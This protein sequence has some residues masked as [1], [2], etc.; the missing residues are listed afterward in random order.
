MADS[1]SHQRSAQASMD[2]AAQR[3]ATLVLGVAILLTTAAEIF[4]L[5]VWGMWLFPDGSWPGKLVWTLTCGL[6][7][8]AVM[9]TLTLIWAEPRR[10]RAAAFWLAAASVA[11]VGSYCA[12]LCSRI[13]ARF[14]YFGGSEH[15]VL[16]VASGVL[17]ALVGGL[18]YGWLLYGRPGLK[19]D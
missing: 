12:W 13:D 9:G 14:D 3:R 7:M 8:G 10:G 5:L 17:P 19:P 11:L 15:G 4:Y 18:L 6:A 2:P 16:F 1:V